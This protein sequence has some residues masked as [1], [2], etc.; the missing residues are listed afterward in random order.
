MAGRAFVAAPAGA[1]QVA[2][3]AGLAFV[4]GKSKVILAP[5][6]YIILRIKNDLLKF[7]PAC[8]IANLHEPRQNP[9][10]SCMNPLNFPL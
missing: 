3:R 8:K 5:P 4:A 1:G 7:Q 6:V 2:V 9:S 10:I